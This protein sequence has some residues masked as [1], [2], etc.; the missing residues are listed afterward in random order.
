MTIDLDYCPNTLVDLLQKRALSHPSLTAYTFLENG[1]IES[2]SLTYQQ[3]DTKAQVIATQLQSFL[4]PSE[5]VL[6]L[7]PSGLE[8]ICAFFGCLYAGVV[9]IP[10]YPPRRNQNMSRLEAIIIDAQAAAV[11]TTTPLLANIQERIGENPEFNVLKFLATDNIHTDQA[12]NWQEPAINSDT[13]AFLQYTSGSTGTPK[14]V[15]VSHG[16]LLYNEQMI[17]I[18]FNHSK[19]TIFAGWLP[20]FH[21]MGLI[22][23]VLQPMY[24]GIPCYLMS[25]VDFIQKPYRWLAAISRYKATTSGGPNFAY[26]LC[27]RK[28]TPDQIA[29][30]DL[31][32]WEVAFNGAEPIHAQTLEK[33]ATTFA[34]CGFRREAFYPC[35]GMAETT[36]LVSGGLQTADP[37]IVSVAEK[38]LEQNQ[39]ITTTDQQNSRKIVGCGQTWLDQQIAIVDPESLTLRPSHQVGEIWVSEPS[40]SSRLLAKISTDRSHL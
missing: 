33:F 4:A 23:N 19:K 17:Q 14:G 18:A 12:L 38:A 8:F 22:G 2:D 25:P 36:L 10:A 31:S 37:V 39:I 5:R 21:D 34:S 40:C 24:L 11:L 27:V 9:A 6:L 26:D 7:Y 32:S 13:L 3:L 35:Y 20:L 29:N 16:N 1:E 15:M 28:I 30:L